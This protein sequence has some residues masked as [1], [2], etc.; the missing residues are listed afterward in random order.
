MQILRGCFNGTGA[1]VYLCLGA[2]PRSFKYM[3]VEVATNPETVEWNDPMVKEVLAFGGIYIK[4]SDGVRTKLTTTGVFPYEGGDMLT[5]TNQTSVAYGEGVYLGW[6]LKNYQADYDYGSGTSGSP[7]NTWTLDTSANRTGHWNVAKVASGNR[8]GAG[9]IIRIKENS[10]GLVKQSAVVAITSDGEATDEVTLSRAIG[11][12]TIT[13]IGGMYDLA[14]IALGKVTPAGVYL[15]GETT[16]NVN[17][18][19][20][21]FE[22][23]IDDV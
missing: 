13:F 17:N 7:I 20:I 16:V 8:I 5:A 3:N 15:A 19:M 6:D 11:S 1:A 2:I 10:S 22:A 21:V 9:S 14:P 12:G 4:G 18:N 23:A